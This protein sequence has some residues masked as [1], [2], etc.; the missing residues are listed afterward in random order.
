[1]PGP[2]VFPTVTGVNALTYPDCLPQFRYCSH[3]FTATSKIHENC[4]RRW[5][6]CLPAQIIITVSAASAQTYLNSN[7][8]SPKK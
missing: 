5:D 8:I 6:F 2:L 1:M 7:T 3:A 4:L